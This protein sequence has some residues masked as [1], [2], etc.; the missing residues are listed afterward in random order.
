MFF[1][2]QVSLPSIWAILLL[3]WQTYMGWSF[4]VVF[5]YGTSTAA[6]IGAVSMFLAVLLP[7]IALWEYGFYNIV[8]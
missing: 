7:M 1:G 5:F 3:L 2:Q 8:R 4:V 6:R